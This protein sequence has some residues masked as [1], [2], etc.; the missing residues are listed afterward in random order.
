MTDK[1]VKDADLRLK[2]QLK[3]LESRVEKKKDQAKA[4]IKSK[5]EKE[6]AKMLKK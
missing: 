1:M 6:E 5:V 3:L 4:I 2:N